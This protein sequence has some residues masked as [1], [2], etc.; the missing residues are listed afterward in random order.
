MSKLDMPMQIKG[1]G[2]HFFK[3]KMVGVLRG[4]EHVSPCREGGKIYNN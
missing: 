1:G 4:A 2:R 3:T